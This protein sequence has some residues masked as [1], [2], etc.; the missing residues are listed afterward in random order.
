MSRLFIILNGARRPW[1][2]D[3]RL[4][5]RLV[6]V[7]EAAGHTVRLEVSSQPDAGVALLDEARAWNADTL[8]IGGGD[9][10]AHILVNAA[11]EDQFAI[12]VLP[13]GTVN[14][15]L[16]RS[17]IR[18]FRPLTVGGRLALCFVSAGFDARVVHG[19]RSVGGLKRWIGKYAYVAAALRQMLFLPP[20][21]AFDVLVD[22]Q[23]AQNTARYRGLLVSRISN[24]AGFPLFHGAGADP[25]RLQWFGLQGGNPL[26][27]AWL[28]L[29]HRFQGLHQPNMALSLD[30]HPSDKG[31]PIHFQADG[32]AVELEPGPVRIAVS[33]SPVYLLAP[34]DAA[35]GMAFEDG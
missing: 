20:V 17:R 13:M 11:R 19:V 1:R 14:E 5:Q 22:E 34:A 35:H 32:E 18:A 2:A 16:L 23:T 8:W 27:L 4:A 3:G 12:G 21:P 29:Q 28:V 26:D 9:G 10:T 25:F 6:A 33:E 24:Y 31:S 15:V 7:A 30:I